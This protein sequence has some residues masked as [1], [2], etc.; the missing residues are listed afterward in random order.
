LASAVLQITQ[1][2]PQKKLAWLLDS[3]TVATFS[4]T[5]FSNTILI[6][7]LRYNTH[8]ITEKANIGQ[9]KKSVVFE[10]QLFRHSADIQSKALE[11]ITLTSRVF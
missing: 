8:I 2:D 1:S 4:S 5:A 10:Q 6:S 3:R 7:C 11:V 9:V